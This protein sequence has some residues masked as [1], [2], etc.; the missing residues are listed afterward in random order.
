MTPLV[1]GT[2]LHDNVKILFDYGAKEVHMRIGCP[3][4]IYGCPFIGFTA[5][6]SD[7]ELITRQI[8]K[9]L[10]GDEN[11]NLDKYATTGSPE[12]EKMVGIIAK[13]FGLS[14]LKFNTIETLIEA[15]GLQSV[16]FVPIV[17]T[18]PVVS[19]WLLVTD[20][21]LGNKKRAEIAWQFTALFLPL[22]A[23]K[24]SLEL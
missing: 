22:Q 5:S 15:I 14:S 4:L 1:R 13:R 19:K 9:E 3:P 23:V 16:K 20:I 24:I 17:L 8:I 10:E 18:D 11:K 2:Q 12:Y 7:M 6:K 21:R